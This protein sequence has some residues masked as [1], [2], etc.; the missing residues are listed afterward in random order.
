MHAVV[1]CLKPALAPHIGT[2]LTTVAEPSRSRAEPE[3]MWFCSEA[4][5]MK[6]HSLYSVGP[7]SE[8]LLLPSPTAIAVNR[9]ASLLKEEKKK[10]WNTQ[11][12]VLDLVSLAPKVS[13]F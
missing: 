9:D 12:S 1:V 13:K 6:L 3:E 8:H 10:C 4:N 5:K 7:S 2:L 11:P